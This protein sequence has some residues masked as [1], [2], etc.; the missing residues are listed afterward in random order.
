MSFENF[1]RTVWCKKI[2]KKLPTITGLKNHSDLQY[3]GDVEN[4]KELKILGI[5][6]IAIKKYVKG[7]K[8]E[9]DHANDKSQMLKLDQE[10]YFD[11][12][13]YDVDKAQSNPGVMEAYSENASQGLSETAD[14]YIG[15]LVADAT[16]ATPTIDANPHIDSITIT[17][18]KKDTIVGS[19]EEAFVK[20]YE[21]NVK[22][23][24]DL[25]LELRPAVFSVFRQALTELFTNNVE[26]AKQGIVG[27]YSHALVSIENNLGQADGKYV[28]I[29]RTKKAVAYAGCL[30][31]IEPFRPEDDFSDALKGLYVFG[32]RIVNPEQIVGIIG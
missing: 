23:T 27:K 9:R 20:L 14:K 18:L 13:V 19:V 8:L 16:L 24:Q 6:D 31:S 30:R 15:N 17:S 2:N 4:A 5:E 26:M 28:N 22:T 3:E 10:H 32:A 7:T 21:N 12:D 11:F 25:H 29:L 1:Q